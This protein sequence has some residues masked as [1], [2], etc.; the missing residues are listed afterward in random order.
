M[1]LEIQYGGIRFTK[2]DDL[3]RVEAQI[4]KVTAELKVLY[5]VPTSLIGYEEA[6]RVL[7]AFDLASAGMTKDLEMLEKRRLNLLTLIT[8]ELIA[9]AQMSTA[10]LG[11]G[12]IPI[13]PQGFLTS[14]AMRVSEKSAES[15][16]GN[17]W[18]HWK[19]ASVEFVDLTNEG[20][21]DESKSE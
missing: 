9:S 19:W 13:S 10:S 12:S 7:G 20:M 3:K 6:I 15:P 8:Q 18:P 11:S 2:K 5:E 14:V 17:R 16:F 1:P 21:A 4:K